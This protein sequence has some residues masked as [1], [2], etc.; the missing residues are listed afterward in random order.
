MKITI[1]KGSDRDWIEAHRP[2]GTV[3]K[4]TFPKKGRFP[5]DAV[6]LI[7][8]SELVY[9]FGFWGRVFD[10]A[11]PQQVAASAKS[12][13]HASAKRSNHPIGDVVELVVAERLVECFEAE[14]SSHPTDL[15]TF[16]SILAAGCAESNVPAPGLSDEQIGSI[17]DGLT[18]MKIQWR[19][20]PSGG[21]LEFWWTE[22]VRST[23]AKSE[24]I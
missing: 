21:S 22:P 2:D 13:G 11:T 15:E 7:V 14:L 17:R 6:H 16:R 5:H 4:T 18:G 9:R 20:S 1:T 23:T 19:A 8:E 10:G 3:M 24:Y 12:G